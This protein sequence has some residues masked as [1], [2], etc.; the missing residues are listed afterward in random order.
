MARTEAMANLCFWPPESV[1]GVRSSN[2]SRRTCSS[3]LFTRR[4][5]SS[6]S[7]SKFSGPKA[8]SRATLVEKSWASKSWKT[9]PTS[10]ANSPTFPSRVERPLTRTS[11]SIRPRKKWGIKPFNE[12]HSVLFPAPECPMTTTNSPSATSRLTP[13]S[14]GSLCPL[15]E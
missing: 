12:V 1:A 15:Y 5:I 4:I 11:P 9:S 3:T 8:T 10:W 2:P 7:T 6:R 14:A 13:S